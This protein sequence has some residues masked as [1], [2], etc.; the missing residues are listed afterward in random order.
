VANRVKGYSLIELLV[1]VLIFGVLAA[2]ALPSYLSQRRKAEV[3]D[4]LVQMSKGAILLKEYAALN[5][6]YPADQ[7][8]GIP[9][10]GVNEWLSPLNMPWPNSPV[11]YESW[12]IGGGECLIQITSFGPNRTRQSPRYVDALLGES[13]GVVGDD[14]ILI[15]ERYECDRAAGPV[16]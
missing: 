6:K 15:V 8:A 9:P 11:D 4:A 1:V 10:I 5:G 3:A 7:N 12:G 2:I 13:H 16:N 14:V